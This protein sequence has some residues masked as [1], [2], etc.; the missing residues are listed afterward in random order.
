MHMVWFWVYLLR[1]IKPLQLQVLAQI[2][3]LLYWEIKCR[4]SLSSTWM[5][6]GKAIMVLESLEYSPNKIDHSRI[7]GLVENRFLQVQVDKESFPVAGVQGWVSV[8]LLVER[9]TEE[10]DSPIQVSKH[11]SRFCP[12]CKLQRQVTVS[13]DRYVFPWMGDLPR[14][15][16]ELSLLL[17]SPPKT[18]SSLMLAALYTNALRRH[19][20][21]WQLRDAPASPSTYAPTPDSFVASPSI[22]ATHYRVLIEGLSF[23]RW[24]QTWCSFQWCQW[25]QS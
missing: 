6:Q 10:V 3:L 4:C 8:T 18:L 19:C 12:F 14:I 1:K 13:N 15:F 23:V 17:G 5:S 21:H 20:K 9:G 25:Y 7:W 2:T 16:V 11:W 22:F 24:V